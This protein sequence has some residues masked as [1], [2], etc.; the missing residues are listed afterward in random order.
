MKAAVCTRYGPPEVLEVREVAKPVPGSRDVLIRIRAAAVSYSEFAIR[1]G[2][3]RASLPLR[4]VVW[5]L[6]GYRGPRKSIMGLTLAGEVEATGRNVTRFK[7]GDRVF[8]Y[9]TM[10][11]GAY[12]EY[13]RAPERSIIALTPANLTDDEAA[14]LPYG[15]LIAMHYLRLAKLRPD[16]R[17]LVYGASGAVGTAAVQ[18]AK[19]FGANVTAVCGPTNLDLVRSLGAD[20]VLDY[21]KEDGPGEKRFDLVFDTVGKWRTSAFKVACRTAL[22]PGGR[23]FSVDVGLPWPRK[24]SFLLLREL[25]EAGKLKAVIDR[26]YPLEQIV[27]AH[28]YAEQGHKKGNVILTMG[29]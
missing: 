28:R 24:D 6:I 12:A 21:T 5:L 7:A 11:G 13:A 3:T 16:Q 8:A 4:I 29:R 9:T 22:A 19:H 26:R 10:R 25:A 17:V 14:A 20:T 18:L 2:A 15:G 23:Y 1:R 27:E